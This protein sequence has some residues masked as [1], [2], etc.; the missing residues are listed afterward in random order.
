MSIF[1]RKSDSIDR[2]FKSYDKIASKIEALTGI[3]VFEDSKRQPVVDVRAMMFLLLNVY[4]NESLLG[5]ARYFTSRGRKVNHS[6]VYYNINIYN[7]EIC[8]RRDDLD[9]ILTFLV[10]NL[11][12]SNSLHITINNVNKPISLEQENNLKILIEAYIETI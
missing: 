12:K 4:Y 11:K 7:D 5:I 2:S 6:T 10:E 9:K 8:K 3:N 1:I